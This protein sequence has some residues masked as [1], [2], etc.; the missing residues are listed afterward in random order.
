MLQHHSARFTAHALFPWI[1]HQLP[2]Y[3]LAQHANKFNKGYISHSIMS[4]IISN[5]DSYRLRING[6]FYMYAHTM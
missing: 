5:S 2:S 4:N 3:I 1:M 6:G